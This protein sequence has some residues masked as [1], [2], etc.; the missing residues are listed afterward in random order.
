MPLRVFLS[1]DIEGVAGV[2]GREEGQ[3][4]NP[5]YERA[6]RLM[7]EEAN[8]AIAGVYDVDSGAEVTV[9]DAHGS[10]RNIIPELLDRRARVVRGK[11]RE[12]AMI[13][14]VQAGFDAAMFVGYHG[15]AGAGNSV[16]SHTYTGTLQ[17]VR[18]NGRSFGEAGLN[19]AVAGAFGVPLK[20]VTGDSSVEDEVHDL[21][22]DVRVVVVK[23]GV[24]QLAANSVHPDVARERIRAGAADAL[25]TTGRLFVIEGPVSVDVEVMIPA[26]ADQALMIPGITRL[27]GRELHYDAPDYIT[28]YRVVRLIAA[29]SGLPL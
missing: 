27:S 16:L 17:D 15:R 4:G 23:E 18:I 9:A 25:G 12:L 14:G 11:P 13:E 10:F 19:A 26:Y 5:E 7:T 24:G 6:R 20:L 1:V 22:G 2:V 29:L 3:S 28:A 8:A 21:L